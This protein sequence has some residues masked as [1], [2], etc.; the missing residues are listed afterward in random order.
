MEFG[1][2]TVDGDAWTTSE[3]AGVTV[4]NFWYAACPPCRVEAPVLVDLHEE[5]S[6]DVS[7]VGVNVRDGAAGEAPWR[8]ANSFSYVLLG[9]RPHDRRAQEHHPPGQVLR[10]GRQA[11]RDRCSTRQWYIKNG[12][13]DADL[14]E[15]LIE[16]G[17]SID[18]HPDHMR[19]RYENWVNGLTGDWLISR[20][21]FFGVPVPVWYA[22]D[23][24]GNTDYDKVLLPT[25]DQLPLDPSTDLQQYVFVPSFSY[26]LLTNPIRAVALPVRNSAGG[27]HPRRGTMTA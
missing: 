10:E 22:L 16:L 25:P 20:Q 2:E 3:N 5:Y 17:R 27:P 19:V 8:G 1:G 4:V 11:A 7:F 9:R 15:R 21:R 26:V 24:D 18:W 14:R 12:G 6:S 23:A 13:R